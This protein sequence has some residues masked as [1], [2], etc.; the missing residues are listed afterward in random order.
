VE[1]FHIRKSFGACIFTIVPEYYQFIGRE[2]FQQ[3]RVDEGSSENRQR[4]SR[5]FQATGGFMD[6]NEKALAARGIAKRVSGMRASVRGKLI[7]SR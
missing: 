7:T 5:S 4:S 1:Y 2:I 3:K 6:G